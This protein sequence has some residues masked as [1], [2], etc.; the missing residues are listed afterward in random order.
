MKNIIVIVGLIIVT[1]LSF[2]QTIPSSCEGSVGVTNT[3]LKSA[4]RLTMLK[5]MEQN[6]TYLDSIH[7][8]QNHVDTILNALIAVYNATGLAARD[9]V[10]TIYGIT[11]Q[12]Y[13][14]VDGIYVQ[15]DTTASWSDSLDN[16]IIPTGNF[17]IDSLIDAHYL[18]LTNYNES[19]IHNYGI[20][21]FH[22]DSS[23]NIFALADAFIAEPLV[24]GSGLSA[25]TMDGNDI[26]CVINPDH[27]EL[28]YSIGWGDCMSGCINHRYWVFK[29][30]YDCS[31]EYVG[32]YGDVIYYMNIVDEKDQE[33]VVYPNPFINQIQVKGIDQNTPYTLTNISGQIVRSGTIENQT[34]GD[35]DDLPK[36]AY[37]LTITVDEDVITK[38]VIK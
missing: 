25:F 23:Y 35:L 29:V 18:N 28:T 37:L 2:G 8:P 3:Y 30:Y 26:A 33:N 27:V 12:N 11:A 16:G 14:T 15:V 6:S 9:T 22:S 5:F 36:G 31:V 20:A 13:P 34:I 10:V 7:I 21:S 24:L 4:Q 17:Y 38:T 32:S 1:H 19:I